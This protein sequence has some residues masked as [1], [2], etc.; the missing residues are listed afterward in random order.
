[1]HNHQFE[2]G[3]NKLLKLIRKPTAP[4]LFNPW[5][6]Q[7][8]EL[9]R[10]GAAKI[11]TENLRQYLLAHQGATAI[12]VG[13]ACGWAGCR[14]TGIPFTGENLLIG[15]EALEWTTG[16]N[17]R[18]SSSR[19][20]PYKERSATTVWGEIAGDRNLVLWNAV[21]WHP[22]RPGEALTNRKPSRSDQEAGSEA[23]RIFLETFENAEPVAIGRVSQEVLMRLGFEAG[24]IR[25][26]SMGGH[27]QFRKGIR[28]LRKRLTYPS[29][30]R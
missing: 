23:L 15:P 4:G 28:E 30:A 20:E 21:P 10:R 19:Q 16:Q 18:R 22:H 7:D 13:E 11:R 8:A 29:R 27:H 17:F 2:L 1:M 14:F 9:D 5:R 6:D 24:Y 3:I 26:P 12:L 25:H